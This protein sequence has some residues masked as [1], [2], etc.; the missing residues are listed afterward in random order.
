MSANVFIVKELDGILEVKMAEI[1]T[2][3]AQVFIAEELA[4][5]W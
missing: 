1:E 3:S 4:G 2:D 5:Y